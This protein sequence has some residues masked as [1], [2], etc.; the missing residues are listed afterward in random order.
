MLTAKDTVIDK[1]S[2]FDGG[3]NDNITKPFAIEEL[4]ARIRAILRKKVTIDSIKVS[5]EIVLGEL[6]LDPIKRE[7]KVKDNLIDLTKREFDL[8]QYLLENKNIVIIV[9]LYFKIFGVM[10]SQEK[11]M[12]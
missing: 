4:L 12:P 3:A 1:V 10:I 2:G 8:L 9:K 7:V 5:S 6:S 11:R